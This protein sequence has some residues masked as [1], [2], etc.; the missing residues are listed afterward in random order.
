MRVAGGR[1]WS[2]YDDL[3]V[4]WM[5]ECWSEC[6]GKEQVVPVSQDT[7]QLVSRLKARDIKVAVCTSDARVPTLANLASLGILTLVDEVVCGDDVSNVPK[8]APDNI[9]N[10]CQKLQVSPGQTLMV[11][12][13]NADL[14]MALASKVGLSVAVMSGVGSLEDLSPNAH[15]ILDSVD[16]VESLL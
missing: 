2:E 8:P 9:I 14:K 11:G 4:C 16:Q 3:A 15:V 13:T 10:I 12:D 6:D 1:C 7:V 5:Q